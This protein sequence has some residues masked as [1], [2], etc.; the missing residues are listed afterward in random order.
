[1]KAVLRLMVTSSTY[2]QSSKS[3][4]ELIERDPYNR[5]YARGP[6]FRVTA[7]AVRDIALQASGLLS[8]KVG[9]PSVYPYQPDG[10]WTQLYSSDQWVTSKGED[11]YRRGIYTFWRRTS[12]YPS[13]MSFDAPSRN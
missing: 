7:E 13:F 10:I 12:T 4:S 8:P 9:G 11:K 5:L 3:T 2:R 1:M 6:R